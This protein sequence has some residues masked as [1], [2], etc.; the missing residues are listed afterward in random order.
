MINVPAKIK[1][2]FKSSS[3]RKNIRIHFPNGEQS[4]ICND[5]LVS[6]SFSFTESICS[7]ENFSLGLMESP[8]I[9]FEVV[10]VDS[11]KGA[12]IQVYCEIYCEETI[13]GAEY[14]T[15]LNHYVYSIPYG[16]FIVDTCKRQADLE[17]RKVTAYS[18][19]ID[20]SLIIKSDYIS[21]LN[22]PWYDQKVPV[23]VHIDD[24][25]K[26]NFYNV[27]D[28]KYPV[29]L[30]HRDIGDTVII[31]DGLYT[32]RVLVEDFYSV[33]SSASEI[34]GFLGNTELDKQF[35]YY[36]V[37]GSFSEY[38][39][40]CADIETR[41]IEIYRET[42]SSNQEIIRNKIRD[43]LSGY[44]WPHKSTSI[45]T[46]FIRSV[47][48][49]NSL[50]VYT[51]GSIWADYP[52][53]D[54]KECVAT[55]GNEIISS[56]IG[57]VFNANLYELTTSTSTKKVEYRA[58]S[59]NKI[60]IPIKY[61]I[62]IDDNNTHKSY[63]LNFNAS[64]IITGCYEGSAYE[65]YI[66]KK[67]GTNPGTLDDSLFKI[68][69]TRSISNKIKRRKQKLNASGKVT[70]ST[71]EV[72][73]EYSSD[74][75]KLNE[76]RVRD[77]MASYAELQGKMGRINRQGKFE[78]V[79]LNGQDGLTPSATLYPRANLYPHGPSGGTLFPID[80]I[81]C[82]YEDLNVKPIGRIIINYNDADNENEQS[83]RIYDIVDNFNTND[84]KTYTVSGN[85][86]LDTCTFTEEQILEILGTMGH[87]LK[88]ILYVPC[89]IDLAGRPF[90]EVGDF[91]QIVTLKGDAFITSIF[92]RTIKGIQALRDRFEV[93]VS[94]DDFS[95]SYGSGSSG[96]GVS[97][98]ISSTGGGSS[99]GVSSVNGKT[100]AVNLKASDIENDL[101]YIQTK[102]L[103]YTY[104][105]DT[106]TLRIFGI[107][108]K[109]DVEPEDE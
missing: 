96:S 16:V 35:D 71:K 103:C 94:D 19:V 89:D 76:I 107:N 83:N 102:D 15:D 77:V 72:R 95:S 28:I 67:T 87:H 32:I 21:S 78:L 50:S 61:T 80:Y 26:L 59:D 23:R 74:V 84:Y 101:G 109:S 40:K 17:H 36:K 9:E 1:E 91:I 66:I 58:A 75:S 22:I 29:T 68:D 47:S 8:T 69:F 73:K 82:W 98:V 43:L 49:Y 7:G 56:A 85:W 45:P 53:K 86:I 62:Q 44:M 3:V 90:I 57:C 14:R 108:K 97:S 63:T 6:E 38:L 11:F 42:D 2:L 46:T 27:E 18:G 106:K 55:T 31:Y 10:A 34:Y 70:E 12:T 100:G 30:T 51:G 104:N 37:E 88:D 4:D 13:E 92:R 24:I 25:D 20:E 99:S 5:K 64:S 65:H 105:E 60:I 41:I 52:D 54:S 79:T 39:Q 81:S 48:N 33:G 93:N